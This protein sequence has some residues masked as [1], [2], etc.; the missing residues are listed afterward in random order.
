MYSD[1]LDI[2]AMIRQVEDLKTQALDAGRENLAAQADAV[3]ADLTT[4]THPPETAQTPGAS[5]APYPH[6]RKG[7]GGQ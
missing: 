5:A 7:A 6:V 3:I 2:P 4:K 1:D